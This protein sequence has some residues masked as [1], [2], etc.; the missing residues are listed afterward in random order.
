MSEGKMAFD[1]LVVGGGS[2]GLRAARRVAERGGRVAVVEKARLG[3]TCV[4]LGCVPKKL[5]YY[6][7]EFGG[8]ATMAAAYGWHEAALGEMDWPAFVERKNA[9][10]ARLNGVYERSMRAAGVEV[11]RG[12]ARV[13]GGQCVTVGGQD[14]SAER[15]LLAAGGAPVR[16]G[17][18]GAGL[19]TVSDDLFFLPRLPRRV[20]L[21][22]GGYIALEFAG[23]FAGLGVETVLS[24][25]A[26]LPMR[27]LDEDVR[28]RLAEGMAARGI[29]L[30]AGVSPVA[31]RE[32]KGGGKVVA[33]DGGDSVSA[34]LVVAALGRRAG[35]GDL[36]LETAGV[37]V[38]EDGTVPVDE[39][40]RTSCESVYAI[41]DLLNTPALTPV[42]IAEAE[43]FVR[44][45]F[46]GDDSA[47][48]D[49]DHVP[50]AVFSRPAVATAGLSER[51]ARGR[52]LAVRVCGGAFRAMRSAF[53][54][55]AE[56]SFVKLVVEEGTERVVGAQMVG[57]GAAEIMQGM[58]VAI[59]AGA[60]KPMFDRTVGIHPTS[61]EEFVTL[62][63]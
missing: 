35:G 34:D 42:A 63:N 49:Y 43:V 22:G 60:D 27:G 58:A 25:R 19:A 11:I 45:V 52:G 7:A 4:N 56:E 16:P 17:F 12:T 15:I 31:V 55:D 51:E 23:I 28:R 50:T 26:D 54:G 48:L 20:V 40:F 10:I 37:T 6:A 29:Q 46:D 32:E 18:E 21:L 62:P 8:L 5:F 13:T 38:R 1:L 44:R 14:F 61:A 30:L 41:G 36:G 53:A 33:F 47:T 39:S 2:G 3:G 57:E 59:A 9:E 24:Y